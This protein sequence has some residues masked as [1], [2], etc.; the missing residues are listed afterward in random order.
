MLNT[1]EATVRYSRRMPE[2]WSDLLAASNEALEHSKEWDPSEVSIAELN[3]T[4]EAVDDEALEACRYY[5]IGL[6][7]CE[8]AKKII[9][10]EVRQASISW[11]A[12]DLVDHHVW[13][14]SKPHLVVGSVSSR[15]MKLPFE[16]IAVNVS[17]KIGRA[18]HFLANYL[19]L[20]ADRRQFKKVI[21]DEFTPNYS[22][23]DAGHAVGSNSV[24]ATATV[25]R[26]LMEKRLAGTDPDE[27]S[28]DLDYLNALDVR[29]VAACLAT[30]RIDEFISTIDRDEP[31]ALLLDADSK[32]VLDKTKLPPTPP[33]VNADAHPEEVNMTPLHDSR[34]RCPAIHVQGLLP[35]MQGIV[36]E[37]ITKADNLVRSGEYAGL[38]R[39]D[40]GKV[41]IRAM[42][43]EAAIIDRY[44]GVA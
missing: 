25:Y 26:L 18:E 28:V 41:V 32:P 39:P 17:S 31:V 37:I 6:I 3:P 19:H 22:R 20:E 36:V 2:A 7:A 34:L 43:Q 8:L 21:G 15:Q 38:E 30:L 23:R 35:I 1:E 14:S 16:Y 33:Q 12:T 13:R 40:E 29:H 42:P 44:L 4:I 11:A 24:A 9:I 10:P 5:A 27:V